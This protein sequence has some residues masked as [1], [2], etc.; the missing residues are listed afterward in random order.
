MAFAQDATVAPTTRDHARLGCSRTDSRCSC[1]VRLLIVQKK[2]IKTGC[3]DDNGEAMRATL[4]SSLVK[5]GELSEAKQALENAA[6]AH[7]PC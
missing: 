6:L 7:Y 2:P 1:W 4:T 5:V 3:D